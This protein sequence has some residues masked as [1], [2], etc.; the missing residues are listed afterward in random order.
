[1]AIKLNQQSDQ[2]DD[3]SN[4]ELKLSYWIL[5]NKGLFKKIAL[6]I[7]IVID[8]AFLLYGLYGFTDYLFITGPNERKQL[9][10]LTEDINYQSINARLV[11][12]PIEIRSTVVL[13]GKKTYDISSFVNNRNE[14]W[15]ATFKYQFIAGGEKTELKEGF[16]L[17]GE[18]KFLSDF[19]LDLPRGTRQA[20]LVFEELK[21]ERV[22]KHEIPDYKI[23]ANERLDFEVSNV[24][25][26]QSVSLGAGTASRASFDVKN[27][28]VFDYWQVG[29][30]VILY[31]GATIVGTNYIEIPR[32]LSNETRSAE[33]TWFDPIV[34]VTKVEVLPE[35]NIFDEGVYVK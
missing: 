18:S 34:Q 28:T 11:A 29:L 25:F 33:I 15:L 27:N 5:K 16:I 7:F 26:D 19:G 9:E 6:G 1:M 12:R 14:D 30:N 4:K 20:L 32:F 17:P 23:W 3:F 24:S 10:M 13:P 21:W 2:S 22:S 35:I 8:A 31:R